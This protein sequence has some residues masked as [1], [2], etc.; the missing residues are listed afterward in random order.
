MV[1]VG[2]GSNFMCWLVVF[3][4]KDWLR[5]WFWICGDM[6]LILSVGEMLIILDSLRMI[7]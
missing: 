6:G 4:L 7:W 3:W 2:M 1:W 5:S